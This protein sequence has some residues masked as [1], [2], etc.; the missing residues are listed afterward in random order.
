MW[1]YAQQAGDQG[2]LVAVVGKGHVRGVVYV[3]LYLVW[4]ASQ[5]EQ[6][7]QAGVLQPSAAPPAADCEPS[8]EGSNSNAGELDT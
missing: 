5:L 3:L 8:F 7:Q 6:Q 2:P 1:R 4:L